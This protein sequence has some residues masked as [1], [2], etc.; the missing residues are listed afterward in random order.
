[1]F[2]AWDAIP[3]YFLSARVLWYNHAKLDALLTDY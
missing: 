3:K 1:M 2:T